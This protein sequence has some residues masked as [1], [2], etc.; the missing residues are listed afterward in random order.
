MTKCDEAKDEFGIKRI[1]AEA[2]AREVVLVE[3]GD[4]LALTV[5]WLL[6]EK[7]SREDVAR[8]GHRLLEW[9]ELAAETSPAA[10][11]LLAEL[12]ELRAERQAMK[13]EAKHAALAPGEEKK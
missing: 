12:E 13:D 5:N 7:P 1:K 10:A 6:E 8:A 11:A 3:A 4:R 2:A 9:T